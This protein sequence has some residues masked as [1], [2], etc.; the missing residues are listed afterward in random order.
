MRP[1]QNAASI[2]QF[3]A[4]KSSSEKQGDGLEIA[5]NK[6]RVKGVNRFFLEKAR[7]PEFRVLL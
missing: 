4:Q 2:R 1:F 6:K 3:G 7:I 5:K